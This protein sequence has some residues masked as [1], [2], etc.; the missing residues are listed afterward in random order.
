VNVLV[1][2]TVSKNWG[3]LHGYDRVVGGFTSEE[4][5][6]SPWVWSC[7]AGFT[8]DMTGGLVE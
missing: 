8:S 1:N 6:G 5:R 3:V 4:L 7:G 2:V